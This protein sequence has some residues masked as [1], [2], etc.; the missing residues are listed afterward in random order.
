MSAPY[1][2]TR[3]RYTC[4]RNMNR[5]VQG[6]VCVLVYV[7]LYTEINIDGPIHTFAHM[8]IQQRNFS[9]TYHRVSLVL[10]R[11]ALFCLQTASSLAASNTWHVTCECGLPK[12]WIYPVRAF[13]SPAE[14]NLWQGFPVHNTK[15]LS[16]LDSC[17]HTLLVDAGQACHH[18]GER[19]V[20]I[21]FSSACSLANTIWRLRGFWCGAP[22][23][24]LRTQTE[25]D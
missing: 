5:T 13:R 20:C 24:S 25:H 18:K 17:L 10:N 7:F 16:R 11:I 9:A 1:D 14:Q 15:K 19:V 22:S 8:H 3:L 6:C 2:A 21:N 23:I 4:G 12:V